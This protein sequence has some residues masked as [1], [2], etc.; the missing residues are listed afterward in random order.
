[1]YN[2]VEFSQFLNSINIEYTRCVRKASDQPDGD[3]EFLHLQLKT[4]G[5]YP[6]PYTDFETRMFVRI[7]INNSSRA[8]RFKLKM[9]FY[10]S[11]AA[12]AKVRLHKWN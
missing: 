4:D 2:A 9:D 11:N 12:A 7:N 3:P 6:H 5:K 10:S 1:M 8:E